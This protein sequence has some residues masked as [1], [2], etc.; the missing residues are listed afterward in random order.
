MQVKDN[1]SAMSFFMM[2]ALISA[3]VFVVILLR[4]ASAEDWPGIFL[5]VSPEIEISREGVTTNIQSL[6]S[7]GTFTYSFCNLAKRGYW[8]RVR[9]L[10]RWDRL[11]RY[12][13]AP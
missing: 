2:A 1:R 13:K 4:C 10:I 12:G 5:T 6:L 9:Q 7:G 8:P 3:W 11:Q